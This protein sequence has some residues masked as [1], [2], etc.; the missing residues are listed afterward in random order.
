MPHRCLIFSWFVC[1][2]AQD[3]LDRLAL[4][5]LMIYSNYFIQGYR[6]N[7][8]FAVFAHGFLFDV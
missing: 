5:L 4:H 2:S 8:A 3:V 1:T 6:W 7:W